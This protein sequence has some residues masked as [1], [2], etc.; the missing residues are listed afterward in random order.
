[1]LIP[2]STDRPL[3]R[4]TLVTFGLIAVCIGVH[5]SR[6]FL[7]RFNP[8]AEQWLMDFGVLQGTFRAAESPAAQLH[9]WQFITYQFLHG[10]FMHLLGNMIF[11]FVF[12]PAVEDRLRRWWFLAFYLV[13]GAFAGAAHL[14]FAAQQIVGPS[15]D[16]V[17]AVP[18]VLGASGSIACVTG[19]YLVLFPLASIRVLVFFFLIGV[20]HIP[21]WLMIVFAVA[22][23][24]WSSAWHSG[25]G[26]AFEA[27]LGGYFYGAGL[28]FLLL[29][30][31]VLPREV[32]DLLSMG[33]QAHRRRVFRELASSGNSPWVGDAKHGVKP[34]PSVPNPKA[35]RIT[36]L[37]AK[38][39]SEMGAGNAEGGTAAYAELLELAPD[40]LMPRAMQS[41]LAS[42][43]YKQG[44]HALAAQSFELLLQRYP[45]DRGA[46]EVRLMLAAINARY[47]NDPVRA[48]SLIAEARAAG[49]DGAGARLADQLSQDLG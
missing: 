1:M 25:G 39:T 13:G 5:L 10:D 20:Y 46:S 33:K 21:A 47:L 7:T 28:A 6:V 18:G 19:A 27:H 44:R 32:Y 43:F 41:E 42:H 29:A 3:S 4:P 14:V 37:R 15:G 31:R 17:T 23:D 12:G 34:T 2:L 35:G 22:K 45:S 49:V 26:V 9:W 24:I 30:F 38:V 16:I 8:A 11:L 36:D 48:K 40:S